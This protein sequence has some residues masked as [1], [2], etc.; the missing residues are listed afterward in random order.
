M[1]KFYHKTSSV[2]YFFNEW[3][4][5]RKIFY[6]KPKIYSIQNVVKILIIDKNKKKMKD[7]FFK[8]LLFW[9]CYICTCLSR[10]TCHLKS[11]WQYIFI[12]FFFSF[13]IKWDF[14]VHGHLM[15]SLKCPSLDPNFWND[16]VEMRYQKIFKQFRIIFS[17]AKK[18]AS[19][20]KGSKQ[21]QGRTGSNFVR[22]FGT[23]SVL[24]LL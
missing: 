14:T 12:G 17:I 9:V 7:F 3:I 1:W 21:I 10:S 2:K 4:I 13:I 11:Y 8:V 6:L 22:V 16:S 18:Q 24:I 23:G 20:A 5:W 19:E 15:D